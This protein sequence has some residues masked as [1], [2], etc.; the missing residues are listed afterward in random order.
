VK[1]TSRFFT[2]LALL[3]VLWAPS[4]MMI[5]VLQSSATPSAIVAIRWVLFALSL[6]ILFA[7]PATRNIL[8][9]T[10]PKGVDRL[11]AMF[12][13]AGCVSLAYI[14]YSLAVTKTSSI[15]ANVLSASYPVIM[16][17]FAFM[18]L[19][20]RVKIQ[21]WIS[22]AIGVVGT[23]IVAVGFGFPSL[24]SQHS[25]GNFLF[26]G[27]LVL[28]CVALTMAT[29][30]ILRSSGLGTLAFEATG[31]AIGSV[32]YALLFPGSFPLDVWHIGISEVLIMV[33]L[34][35]ISGVFAFGVWYVFVEK[36][37]VSLMMLST[38]IQPPIAA[39]CGYYFLHEAISQKT[40]IG[41]IVIALSLA[42]A[43]MDRHSRITHYEEAKAT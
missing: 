34:F 29:R 24:S 17:F 31:T 4:N 13:G 15:E 9:P 35:L 30:I 1:S 43:A 36:A 38:L 22:I 3:N 26:V 32:V 27:G 7:I 33:Y 42:V 18:F 39:V 14:T 6:W 28:E 37:P 12:I 25:V 19:Q 16:G 23:Y 40:L 2:I 8:K 41:S 10:L 5:K 11:K 20:E 21:R